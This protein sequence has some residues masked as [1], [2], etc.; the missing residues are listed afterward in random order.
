[1]TCFRK[2][3]AGATRR[4]VSSS[5]SL[6][7]PTHSRSVVMRAR[8]TFLFRAQTLSRPVSS[9]SPP[10]LL[11]PAA[12]DWLHSGN[13]AVPP[14]Q[15]SVITRDNVQSLGNDLTRAR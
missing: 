1:M 7:L 3:F 5:V 12:M 9:D 14:T 10:W 8:G 15:P 11:S 13:V 6:A 2:N 4:N